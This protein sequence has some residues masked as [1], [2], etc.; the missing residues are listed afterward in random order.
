MQTRKLLIFSGLLTGALGTLGACVGPKDSGITLISG[1]E[2]ETGSGG[3]GTAGESAQGS[4]GSTPGSAGSTPGGSAGSTPGSAGSTPG[5]AGSAGGSTGTGGTT[6]GS[7]GTTTTG[8]G[9]A[10]GTGG[11]TMPTGMSAGCGKVPPASLTKEGAWSIIADGCK[12]DGYTG[13][14]SNP[15][16]APIS[17]VGPDGMTYSRGFYMWVPTSYDSSKPTRVIYEAAGCTNNDSAD[18]ADCGGSSGFPYQ[19]VDTTGNNDEQTIQVGLQYDPVRHGCYDDHDAMSNDFAF[20]PYL[21]KWVEDNFC[22]DLSHQFFSGYSS[23]SWLTNQMTCQFPDVLRGIVEAT[24]GEPPQQPTCVTSGH[25]V[26]ALFLHDIND[27]I[28][29]YAGILPACSRTLKMNGC[30]N[31][32]CSKPTDT[33]VTSA[34]TPPMFTG[35]DGAPSSLNCRQF[36]GCPSTAPVVFCSTQIPGDNLADHYV[37]TGGNWIPKLFWNFFNK[38]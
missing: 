26:A 16:P 35:G 6:P 32:D 18:T 20:F 8:G 4:A 22:V 28:N 2:G 34:Y 23:G 30:T 5:S 33:T 36:D 17:I 24:G 38:F 7:A 25:P 15:D 11:A 37:T 27:T 19:N 10:T 3:A 9:G 29:T 31:T 13:M 14:L 1:S 21:H 12:A